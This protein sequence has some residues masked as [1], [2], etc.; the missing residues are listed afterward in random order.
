[1]GRLFGLADLHLSLASDK[2]MDIFGEVWRD[3]TQ[4]MAD[5]WDE[6]VGAE[7]TVLIA[8]DVSW[9]RNLEEA[10]AD[11]AW[12]GKRPG[13]KLILRGNHDSWWTSIAKVRRILP[14]GCQALQHD[15]VQVEQWVVVGA[16]GWTTPQDPGAQAHDSEVF[17][18]E[19]GRLGLSIA[20]AD[21]RFGRE[22]PRLA[23]AHFPPWLE[24]QRPSEVVRLLQEAGV[25]ACVY[26][27]LHGADHRLAVRGA[28]EGIS[29]YF[30]AAD[31]VGFAPVELDLP[32]PS[33]MSGPG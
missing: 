10:A 19:L 25:R 11:L 13:R 31:A 22:L 21:R 5:A 7:D 20:D 16:R 3:H 14:P 24:G 26:G 9:G 27:H 17:K 29:Y 32:Q 6:R 15:A 12:I 23:M 28:R 33:S 2:P 1:M 4:R 30:V 18:R 8:G